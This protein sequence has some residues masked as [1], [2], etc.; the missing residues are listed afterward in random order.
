MK[1]DGTSGLGLNV[2]PCPIHKV[3]RAPGMLKQKREREG[4]G[5]EGTLES[6]LIS[7]E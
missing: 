4:V 7:S 2:G 5:E 6:G 1:P 3:F